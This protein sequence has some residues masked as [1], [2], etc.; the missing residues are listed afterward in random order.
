MKEQKSEYDDSSSNSEKEDD[1]SVCTEVTQ[2]IILFFVFQ[3]NV[4]VYFFLNIF[5]NLNVFLCF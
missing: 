2:V 5:Y 1:S 3:K 4:F